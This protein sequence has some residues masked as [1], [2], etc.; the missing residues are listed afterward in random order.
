MQNKHS[1]WSEQLRLH[2]L[3]PCKFGIPQSYLRKIPPGK[4]NFPKPPLPFSSRPRRSTSTASG[5]PGVPTPSPAAKPHRHGDSQWRPAAGN[6]REGPAHARPPRQLLQH[7]PLC[8]RWRR[9]RVPRVP[10]AALPHRSCCV[11]PGLHQLHLLRS[12]EL[13]ECSG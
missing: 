6:G 2:F 10:G 13:H 1:G 4:E 3:S 8:G 9:G 12:Q 5:L 7:R 11:A